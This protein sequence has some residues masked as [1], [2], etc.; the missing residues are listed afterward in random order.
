MLEFGGDEDTAIAALLHDSVEDCGGMAT[1]EQIRARFG[2]RVAELV[3]GCSD[4]AESPKPPWRERKTRYLEHLP[5]ASPD[6]LLISAADKLHNLLSLLRD[7]RRH[8]PE[9]WSFF[10]AGKEG[11]LWYFERLVSIF[12][13]S[14]VPVELVDQLDRGYR[15]LLS[16]VRPRADSRIVGPNTP[17]DDQQPVCAVT[18]TK[19]DA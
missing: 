16:R 11:T 5:E 7:E 13:A 2:D 15:E 14:A 8:G 1:L 18:G 17:L 4:T 12:R 3:L 6:V 10:R 19:K 9:L